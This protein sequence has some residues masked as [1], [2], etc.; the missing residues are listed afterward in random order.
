MTL[1]L[2]STDSVQTT[3]D[4]M[5]VLVPLGSLGTLVTS[6]STSV[7][8]P[9]AL[10]DSVPTTLDPMGVLVRLDSLGI[11]AKWKLQQLHLQQVRSYKKI[12]KRGVTLF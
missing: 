1:H 12:E 3:L 9:L 11:L 6:T 8:P 2:A 10:T 5:G 4:P 7:T